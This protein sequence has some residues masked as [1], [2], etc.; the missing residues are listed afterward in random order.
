MITFLKKEW[1]G[2]LLQIFTPLK[3]GECR[4]LRSGH[5]FEVLL[6]FWKQINNDVFF[7]DDN[8]HPKSELVGGNGFSAL[9]N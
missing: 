7:K 3:K 1:L 5:C 8:I 9:R 4:Y 2:I 6:I